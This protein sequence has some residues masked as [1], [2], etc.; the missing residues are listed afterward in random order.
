MS[1]FLYIKVTQVQPGI[2]RDPVEHQTIIN[3]RRIVSIAECAHP[4]GEK[5]Q[6]VIVAG[7]DGEK[8]DKYFVTQSLETLVDML[9]KITNSLAS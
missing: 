7:N 5:I 6:S 1:D 8:A 4:H 9:S 2:G 3:T